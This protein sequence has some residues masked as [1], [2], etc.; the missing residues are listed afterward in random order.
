MWNWG[1]GLWE[2]M[3]GLH[4]LQIL[5]SSPHSHVSWP[6]SSW[7][8]GERPKDPE[9]APGGCASAEAILDGP[10]WQGGGFR[11]AVGNRWETPARKE[12][13]PGLGGRDSSPQACTGWPGGGGVRSAEAAACSPASVS[14][15]CRAGS[16]ARFQPGFISRRS[17][18]EPPEE[19]GLATW[20]W[21]PGV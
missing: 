18:S 15:L 5:G 17:P 7:W 4:R 2:L 16:R 6:R 13:H 14:H 21:G 19:P 8:G 3:L 10:A 9:L 12:E 20:E 1:R 11:H